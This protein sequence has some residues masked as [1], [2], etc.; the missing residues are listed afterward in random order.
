M[1][2]GSIDSDG[3]S[4]ERVDGGVS[5]LRWGGRFRTTR[6]SLVLAAASEGDAARAA[7][8]Q[9]YR[10]YWYPVFALIARR[11][12]RQA[13][14]ELTQK[15]FVNRLVDKG[16]LK[17]V[18]R[19]PGKRF[20]GWLF[21]AV[22]NFLRSQWKFDH[23]RIRDESNTVPLSSNDEEPGFPMSSLVAPD[24]DPE[25]QLQRSRALT[26]L[27][28][29]LQCLRREYC[30]HAAAA[31][32]NAEQRFEI[33]K[34]FLP[35]VDCDTMDLATC[36]REL[37]MPPDAAKQLVARL[38]KRYGQ[39]LEDVLRRDTSSEVELTT[40]KRSLCEALETP[41]PPTPGD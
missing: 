39:L 26:L 12:G 21:A 9:L 5:E 16:D 27:G 33:A 6:W 18:Q 40:A 29:A 37:D 7:L 13:A 20:R 15:F 3:S 35:G 23:Q 28:D 25:R 19:L 14:L 24:R 30:A 38:R 1:D 17:G 8:G 41:V 11:R 22:R 34:L 4:I 2:A 32:V 31:G 36:A 10:T